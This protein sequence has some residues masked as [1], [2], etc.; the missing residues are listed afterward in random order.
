M[1]TVL[2]WVVC[3]LTGPAIATQFE[4]VATDGSLVIGFE[5]PPSI[6]DSARPKAVAAVLEELGRVDPDGACWSWRALADVPDDGRRFEH[7]VN[8]LLAETGSDVTVAGV[9]E[10]W[11]CVGEGPPFPPPVECYWREELLLDGAAWVVPF[12]LEGGQ[13]AGI[14]MIFT[15]RSRVPQ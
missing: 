10:F 7:Y 11:Y 15:L 14:P 6:A 2:L 4:S 3:A 8:R 5:L 12:E 13:L 9:G 1:T